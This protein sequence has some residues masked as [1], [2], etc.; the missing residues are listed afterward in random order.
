MLNT[1]NAIFSQRNRRPN[2]MS[3][4]II[5]QKTPAAFLAIFSPN[6]GY[7]TEQSLHNTKIIFAIEQF[8]Q[9]L[10]MPPSG[11]QTKP[12]STCGSAKESNRVF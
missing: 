12:T 2:T 7:S 8:A 1:Q 3:R 10:K 5:L 11:R 4:R 9:S 6:T